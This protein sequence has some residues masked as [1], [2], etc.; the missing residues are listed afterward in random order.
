MPSLEQLSPRLLHAA[1]ETDAG[2]RCEAGGSEC[3]PWTSRE[4]CDWPSIG[5]AGRVADK[6]APPDKKAASA[7]L[8]TMTISRDDISPLLGG[9]TVQRDG[10]ARAL[11]SIASTNCGPWPVIPHAARRKR[12]ARRRVPSFG[13]SP[14]RASR[15]VPGAYPVDSRAA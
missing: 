11:L 6:A 1:T 14:R 9:S 12:L 8:V 3:A 4:R 15:W 7:A 5:M 10:V 2:R 13:Q